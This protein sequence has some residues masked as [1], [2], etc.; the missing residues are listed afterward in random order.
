[1]ADHTTGSRGQPPCASRCSIPTPASCRCSRSVSSARAGSTACWPAPVPL[2]AMVAMRLN[3][4]VVDLAVLGP[5]GWNYLEKLCD[6]L[7]GAR[8]DRLHRPVLGRP[9]RARAAAGR[10]R[11]GHQAL[12]PR[13][14]DRPRRGGRAPPQAR[15]GARVEAGPVVVGEVEIRAD[16][17]QAFVGG[18]ERRPHAPRVRADPAARRGRGP[19]A[20][21]R[22]DLPA[23]VGL[24][25]GPRRPLGRR[26]RAQA[27]PEARARLAALALHPHPL[28]HRLPLRG[29]AARA[30]RRPPSPRPRP[31]GRRGRAAAE[32]PAYVSEPERRI[33]VT[34]WARTAT[35]TSATSRSSS[36]SRSRSGRSRAAST[37]EQHDLQPAAWSCAAALLFFGYR[38]YMEHR[39]TIFGLERPPARRSCT[40]L[41][42]AAFA[43][44]ATSRLW[45][46]GGLGALLWFACSGWPRGHVHRL[47]RVSGVLRNKFADT[48]SLGSFPT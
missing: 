12:P 3:A 13:G 41:A 47:A 27:A 20:P 8:R 6:R 36:R 37:G 29:R 4:L 45:D 31:S 28:R 33:A 11:L 19:G 22:G 26:L 39:E 14:A 44:V 30:G 40:A 21:A 35:G 7:P 43:L 46:E 10:R 34:A 38:L 2:D 18:V 1:M 42:L 48:A 17:F 25:D 23:R 24:R 9:A 32:P 5:Q 16:Q 15:R